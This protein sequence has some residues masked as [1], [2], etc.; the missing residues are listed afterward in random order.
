[1]VHSSGVPARRIT[2]TH[3]GAVVPQPQHSLEQQRAHLLR[4]AARHRTRQIQPTELAHQLSR[5]RDRNTHTH[6]HYTPRCRNGDAPVM[7]WLQLWLNFDSTAVRLLIKVTAKC[8]ILL[9]EFRWGGVLRPWAR[10]WRTTNVCD[11]W[12]VRR[13]TY[14]Y[15]P[16]RKASPPIG[17]Y[18]IILLGDRGT[19]MLTT[20]PGLHSIAERP[21]FDLATYW[22]QVQRPNHS[23]TEP[24]ALLIT[25]S[26]SLKS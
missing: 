4:I 10:R 13:Q 19:C 22:S 18:Q 6:M 25:I 8:A 21:G 26:R 17:W 3:L 5:R 2:R 11:A 1:M 12:P 7:P 9:L 16:S 23:A 24:H 20:C 15:L 14:G